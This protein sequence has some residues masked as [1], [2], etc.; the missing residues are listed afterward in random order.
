MTPC[1]TAVSW[2]P[3]AASS[4]FVGTTLLIFLIEPL[5]R[6]HSQVAFYAVGGFGLILLY[7]QEAPYW[8]TITAA[9][10]ARGSLLASSNAAWVLTPELY[11]TEIRAT[12]HQFATAANRLCA[13]AT[14]YVA[15]GLSVRYVTV[16]YGSVALV[17]A[18]APLALPNEQRIEL[19]RSETSK[20]WPRRGS[21]ILMQRLDSLPPD[22]GGSRA[23][24]LLNPLG[25]G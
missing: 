10:L 21:S 23:A 8:V 19:R 15:V 17:A 11:P 2:R 22:F 25:F 12:G 5:G 18:L 6:V 20:L 3:I 4:E 7:W 14:Q 13:F 24:S 1:T 9:F 16:V